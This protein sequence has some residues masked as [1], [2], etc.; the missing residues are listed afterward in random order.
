MTDHTI[1]DEL[2]IDSWDIEFM[3]IIPLILRD[4]ERI[5]HL[6]LHNKISLVRLLPNIKNIKEMKIDEIS[7]VNEQ[8]FEANDIGITSEEIEEIENDILQFVDYLPN[9]LKKLNIGDINKRF[10][11][12]LIKTLETKFKELK[13][14]T[15]EIL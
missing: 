10:Y 15:R 5:R 3:E 1:I 9:S 14:T 13:V 4:V 6:N 8:Y 2:R 11:D 7:C 12:H